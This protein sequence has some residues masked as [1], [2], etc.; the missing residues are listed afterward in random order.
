MNYL[1]N[2]MG[3]LPS[4]VGAAAVLPDLLRDL[5]V[6]PQAVFEDAGVDIVRFVDL[7]ALIPQADL[8]RVARLSAQASG[9]PDLGLLVAGRVGARA[10][11]LLGRLMRNA[12]DLRS[13]LNDFVRYGHLSVRSMVAMLTVADGVATMQFALGGALEG[14]TGVYEDAIVGVL[15]QLIREILDESWRPSA[16]RLSHGPGSDADGYREFF[17]APVRF[18]ALGAALEFPATDLDRPTAGGPRERRAELEA[19]ARI[20]SAKLAIGFEEAVRCLIRAHLTDPGLSVE[21]IA[22]LTGMSRRTLN[23]RLAARGVTVAGLL[24]SV[25]FASARQLLVASESPLSEVAKAVG[26]NG[27]SVFSHAFRTW[28]GVSPREWRKQRG[29]G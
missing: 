22:S 6:A 15:V 10:M 28:S 17:G 1:S 21:Q 27:P 8:V 11:G 23:R 9:R 3:D 2:P 18:N 13:A 19:S 25:R 16:V 7:E 4:R 5:G 20:A 24:Q 14:A 12:A 29:R 26:Y